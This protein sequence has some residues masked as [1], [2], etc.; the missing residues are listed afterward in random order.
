[1]N[2]DNVDRRY[3]IFPFLVEPGS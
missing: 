1:M 3:L 2:N